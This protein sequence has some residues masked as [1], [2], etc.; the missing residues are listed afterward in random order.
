MVLGENR[1]ELS[2]GVTEN[3]LGLEILKALIS[4]FPFCP[5]LSNIKGA[6]GSGNQIK[7]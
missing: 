4:F 1:L 6:E 5:R 7:K 3:A 2:L